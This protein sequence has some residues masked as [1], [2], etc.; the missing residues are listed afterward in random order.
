MKKEGEER[1]EGKGGVGRGIERGR[2][3]MC[4]TGF[5]WHSNL[6]LLEHY[7]EYINLPHFFPFAP[8]CMLSIDST[9]NMIK[10]S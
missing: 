5:R 7:P 8:C 4:N 9:N 10:L 3:N 2:R 1:R 6:I